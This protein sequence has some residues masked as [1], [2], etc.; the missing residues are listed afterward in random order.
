LG[1]EDGFNFMMSML[2]PSSLPFFFS[3]VVQLDQCYS[4]QRQK[5]SRS[6][7]MLRAL[8]SFAALTERFKRETAVLDELQ[9]Q[10]NAV[11][12]RMYYEANQA[13][14]CMSRVLLFA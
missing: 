5:V 7:F 9:A 3:L 10:T 14:T 11:I 8:T 6:L 13:S 4:T 1:R 2:C 12:E